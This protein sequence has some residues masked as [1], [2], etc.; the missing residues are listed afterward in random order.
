MFEFMDF[1]FPKHFVEDCQKYVLVTNSLL[2]N[3]IKRVFNATDFWFQQRSRLVGSYVKSRHH[4]S[5]QQSLYG[6]RT[7]VLCSFLRTPFLVLDQVS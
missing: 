4:V 7:K 5:N 2:F 1:V 3:N 6:F